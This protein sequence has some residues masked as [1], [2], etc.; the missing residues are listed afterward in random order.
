MK[1][2]FQVDQLWFKAPGGIGT[3]VWQLSEALR[4]LE[5]GPE[6]V[7]FRSSFPSDRVPWTV[8][9]RGADV[10][11]PL[12]PRILYPSWAVVGRPRLP[13]ALRSCDVVHATNHAAVPPVTRDKRLVVTV[14][15][16]AFLR[17]PELFPRAW[18][19]QY[20]AALKAAIRRADRL[21]V[22]SQAVA[23]DLTIRGAPEQRIR[24]TPLASGLPVGTADVREVL[25]RLRVARPYVLCAATIEPR[26]NQA[27]LVR[28]YRRVAS[29]VPH[30]LVLAGP[31]G[32]HGGELEK[33]L[34]GPGPG[35]I[36]R[37]GRLERDDLDAVIRG[38]DA[39][40]Y[41]SIYE[42]FGLPLL[43]AMARGIPVLTSDLSALP[44]VAGE[45]ALLVDPTDEDAVTDALRQL[46]TDAQLRVDLSRRGRDRAA[47]FSW[48]ATARATL[49]A[50]R[51]VLA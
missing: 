4:K 12:S 16:L 6:L 21:L 39:V 9:M 25:T 8:P 2:A 50:Y 42:G 44:E 43:E 47:G 36:I 38:A 45:V 51:E 26:K 35:R 31:A 32:W 5:D 30:A 27:R 7:T 3:Y 34:A 37:L 24:V 46:L 48:E 28:A 10:I 18:R 29:E 22:P 33:E 23:N 40:V 15:D 17:F 41:I 49:D 19:V 11:L 20:R 13:E 1:V 14:H